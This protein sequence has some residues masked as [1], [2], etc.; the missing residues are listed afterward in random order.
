MFVRIAM[1]GR[2]FAGVCGY[3]VFCVV[4]SFVFI[5]FGGMCGGVCGGIMFCVMMSIMF[6][7]FRMFFV[8]GGMCGG[9]CG[10]IMFYVMMSIVFGRFRSLCSSCCACAGAGTRLSAANLI[11]SASSGESLCFVTATGT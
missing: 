2:M 1:M 10:G 4:M 9:V 7:R 3:I 8:F 11:S 5:V 6:G